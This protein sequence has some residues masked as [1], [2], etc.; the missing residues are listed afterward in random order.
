[1]SMREDMTYYLVVAI[2]LLWAI[3]FAFHVAG[4]AVHLL[5]VLAAALLVVELARRA[6]SA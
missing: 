5:L 4:A 2:L 6:R 3:G 1:M